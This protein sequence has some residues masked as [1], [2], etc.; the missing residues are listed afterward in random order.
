MKDASVNNHSWLYDNMKGLK[1]KIVFRDRIEYRIEGKLHNHIVPA[2]I[3]K[4][5]GLHKTNPSEDDFE[6]YYLKG[7]KMTKE[8]WNINSR[9]YKIKRLVKKIKKDKN[10]SKIKES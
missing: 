8:Q 2:I 5:D 4:Y 1:E 10:D 7:L 6:E 3:Y 9:E